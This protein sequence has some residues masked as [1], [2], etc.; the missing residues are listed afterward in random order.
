MSTVM[1]GDPNTAGIGQRLI[2]RSRPRFWLYLAG[3]VLV[4]ATFG[5]STSDELMGGTLA[6]L[7][8]YFLVPANL[9]LYGVNDI[10]DQD[11]DT[12]N[13]KKS[14]REARWSEDRLERAAIVIA[15]GLGLGTFL[16]VPPEGWIYLGGFFAFAWIYSAPP[17]RLKTVPGFDSIA[18]GL[19]ILPGAAAFVMLAGSHPPIAAIVGG[20]AWAM[21]MHAFSAIP[22]I[23]SDRRGGIQTIATLL[24]SQRTLGFCASCWIV[25]TLAFASIDLRFVPIF[26][27]YPLFVFGL[28]IGQFEIQRAY[29]WFPPLNASMG[30]V[31]T[32]AGI[33]TVVAW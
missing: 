20:W 14:V 11:L 25:A 26:G 22:D 32:I 31:L 21:A 28:W 13:P 12:I 29:W 6:A 10:F 5:A 9:L 1:Q 19:Y 18:N 30:M 7:F 8:L 2:V 27:V 16:I 33:L 23:S 17:I 4:G 15:G 24:G 3:P